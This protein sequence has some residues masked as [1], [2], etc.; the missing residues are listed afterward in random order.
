M[1]I[2]KNE[3]HKEAAEFLL[4][5]L[6]PPNL[7]IKETTFKAIDLHYSNKQG[8]TSPLHTTSK[9]SIGFIAATRYYN[10]GLKFSLLAKSVLQKKVYKLPLCPPNPSEIYYIYVTHKV[11]G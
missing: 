7:M 5:K 6:L 9:I 3:K 4:N 11:K 1:D 8:Q 2:T 10:Y